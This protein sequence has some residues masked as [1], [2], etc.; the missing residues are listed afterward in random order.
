MKQSLNTLKGNSKKI[1]VCFMRQAGRYLQEYK[2][3]VQ[4]KVKQSIGKRKGRGGALSPGLQCI[5]LQLLTA[6]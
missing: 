3:S 2:K 6:G 4:H 5:L 1:P